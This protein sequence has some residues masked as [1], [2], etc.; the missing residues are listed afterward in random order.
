MLALAVG[1]AMAAIKLL[2]KFH[3]EFDMGVIHVSQS[4]GCDFNDG[5]AEH[6]FA[7]INKAAQLALPGDTVL[8][9][10]GIYRECVHPRWGGSSNTKRIT[11]MAAPNEKVVI[12]GSE[13][14]RGWVKAEIEGA[15]V[16]LF[17]VVLDNAVF[18]DYNPYDTILR[19][20]W[21]MDPWPNTLHTGDVYFDGKSLY[22]ASSLEELKTP[23]VRNTGP[24]SDWYGTEEVIP[25]PE[26]TIFQWF[27]EVD[28]QANTTTIY[29]HFGDYTESELVAH[30]IEINVR[31][32]CF[33]PLQLNTNYITVS[34]FEICQ[35]ATQW[36]PPTG[37]QRG[38][39]DTYWSKGWVIEYCNLHDA[40]TSAISLGKE[41]ATGDNETW[42]FRYKPG[43]QTQL[44]DVFKGLK[45]GWSME[46]IGS[47]EIHHCTM[48]DCGQN[49]VVGHMGCI[50]S[51]IHHNHIY[52]IAMKHEFFG[53]EIAGIKLHAA[54]DVQIH[55]NEFHDCTL[56]TWLDWEAQGTRVSHNVYYDN[57]RD[58]MIEVTH[59]PCLVDNNIFASEY[60]FD[61]VAQGTALVNNLF[62]G[63]TRHIDVLDRATPYHAAHS[64]EV[65]GFAV[66]YSGDDRVY[67][68]VFLGGVVGKNPISKCGT[69]FYNGHCA[70][71]DEYHQKVRATAPYD[72]EEFKLIKDPVYI[73][74]NVY[75]KGAEAFAA[76]KHMVLS[77]VDPKLKVYRD[78]YGLQVEL[79]VPQ[80]M[81]DL[82]FKAIDTVALGETRLSACAYENHDG[83]PLVVDTDLKDEPR[84]LM[85]THVGPFE[86][87]TVGHNKIK[88]WN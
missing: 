24:C 85:A 45:R 60:N 13:I 72:V 2:N 76:E 50:N 28:H 67:G 47:H 58:L 17:K 36:A 8:V 82:T 83:S 44:E 18:G 79:D 52:N 66:V 56:G 48:H 9:H 88:L 34:G 21:L 26:D 31:E 23:L 61:N 64:T 7:T 65:T 40:K 19:G 55:H 6:P 84:S 22:E 78:V 35:A 15:S 41:I 30:C 86:K 32:S 25:H 49:G 42:R 37:V 81:L 11:Y 80:E 77:T 10:G 27:A 5:S 63:T 59:G 1:L 73:N 70:S 46:M 4:N 16:P 69:A 43:Y 12:K 38:M 62:A 20:D 39:V 33:A 74:H 68:N 54:I 14:V 87:L 75:L 71:F 57:Y 53:H 3:E 29:A 51:N